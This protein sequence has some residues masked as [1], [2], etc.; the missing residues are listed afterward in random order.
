[1]IGYTKLFQSIITSTI[2]NESNDCKA[3]WITIL[4][5]KEKD[6]V[7]RATIPS[8]A[9][10]N[11]LTIEQTREFMNKFQE[12]DEF[13]RTK[14]FDG[15]RLK[16]VEG[17]WLV[18]NGEKYRL[19]MNKDEIR[20]YKTIKQREYRSRGKRVDKR[21]RMLT[22]LTHTDSDTK[23][24]TDTNII[25]DN[26]SKC[27]TTN[28]PAPIIQV[29]NAYKESWGKRSNLDLTPTRRRYISNALKSYSLEEV[30]AATERFKA[31]DF[32]DRAKFS[33]I[34]YLFGS[35][36]RID[37]W[38]SLQSATRKAF[39][40]GVQKHLEIEDLTRTSLELAR[41]NRQGANNE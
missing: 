29:W 33:D 1:M 7:C 4:A 30:L 3:L 10:L 41:L 9:K 23:S 21:G 17:G 16:E 8:L 18:L 13:S 40:R 22:M 14:A 34:K 31:D 35:Q 20:E 6:N 27:S 2:W 24:D 28:P 19:K 26:N 39:N 36:D 15:R 25:L 37:K 38:C 12:P 5:L 11:N 32:E